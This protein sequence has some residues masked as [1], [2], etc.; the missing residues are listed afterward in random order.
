MHIQFKCVVIIVYNVTA[1][2]CK[3]RIRF[4]TNENQEKL[5]TSDMQGLV[6]GKPELAHEYDFD[7]EKIIAK[8]RKFEVEECNFLVFCSLSL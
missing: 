5:I 7:V 6:W 2:K 3:E 8:N 4:Y 1:C